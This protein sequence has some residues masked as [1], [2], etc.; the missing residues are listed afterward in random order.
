MLNESLSKAIRLSGEVPELLLKL[1]RQRAQKDAR[2]RVLRV[3]WSKNH[4]YILV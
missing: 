4:L 3:R 1:S 2:S